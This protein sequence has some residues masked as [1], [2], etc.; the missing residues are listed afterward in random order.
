DDVADGNCPQEYTITRTFTAEDECGNAST[1]TQTINVVDTTAPV[2]DEYPIQVDVPCDE[3]DVMTITATDNCGEVTVTYTEFM[4][5]GGCAGSMIRD[6][7][8]VD[9]CGNEAYAQQIISLVDEVAPEAENVPV[10][11]TFECDEEIILSE[12]T[13]TDNCDDDLE[14]TYNEVTEE[15]DCFYQIIRTWTAIDHCDNETTVSQVITVT[16]TTAPSIEAGDDLTI[17]CTAIIPDPSFEV[18]DNCDEDV[19]V[20][21]TSEM[22]DGDCPQEYTMVRTYTA[23]D[24]CGNV[25]VDTQTI[26]VVDTT[27][28]VFTEVAEDVTVEC[29]EELPAP[30]ASAEDNCGEVTI[31]V[32]PEIIDGDCGNEYT[33]VRTYTATDECGNAS[34]ATQTITVVD[35][36]APEFTNV[37]SSMTVECLSDVPDM[38]TLAATDNCGDAEVVCNEVSDL[39]D[40][41]NGVI[42]RT[43]T[44]T[45][46]CGNTTQVSYSIT[47][48]DTTAPA[49]N[50]LPEENLVIDCED[51]VPAP[52]DVTATDNC[53]NDLEVI[54][55]EEIIGDLPA[56]GSSA[57]CVATTPEAYFEGETCGGTDPWSLVLFNFGGEEAALYNTIEANWV[58]YPDGTATLTGSVFCNDNPDAG[59]EINVAFENGMPWTE[60]STQG[61]PTGYKDD[62]DIAG[63]NFLDWMYYIMS[64]GATLTGWGDYEG[65]TLNLDHAPSNLYYGYQV[66]VAANNVNENYGSG[67][68]FTY[69]GEFNGDEVYG[70]GDFAFDHDC[71]PQYSVERTWCVTDCSGNE[72]CFTQM[73]SFDDL[74]DDN[75]LVD[76]DFEEMAAERGDFEIVRL[77]PN[78]AES[79]AR[80]EVMAYKG[81]PVRIEL[82][83]LNGKVVDVIFEGDLSRGQTFRTIVNTNNLYN[84]VYTV[85]AYSQMHADVTKLVIQK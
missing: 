83:D 39:D 63:D 12:P 33:M 77:S 26:T 66:G 31:D 34:T 72:T 78:P 55:T 1:A 60:W 74:S 9:E 5:S 28:P 46:A 47:I 56:E 58:E 49:L 8:A 11:T 84:G 15:L 65:A 40:C 22:F 38:M 44:A 81:T 4:I 19:M 20:D 41:G 64:E 68:W 32:S 29:D 6:Y 70:S 13:F 85:R 62:C 21:I 69:S 25:S 42:I 24:D 10:D 54:F 27:A 37:P 7:V 51:D 45:D 57:D 36:T 50:D 16:D 76:L 79:Y 71:C 67:G 3:V 73:I 82:V 59:W 53:D 30:F 17:E 48:N 2:F 35:T 43:C 14:I 18:S 80:V 52:A 75:P 61:F 23:T